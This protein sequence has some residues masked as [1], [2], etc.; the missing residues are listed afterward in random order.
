MIW[1]VLCDTLLAFSW[2]L[3]VLDFDFSGALMTLKAFKIYYPGTDVSSTQLL[4]ELG[5]TLQQTNDLYTARPKEGHTL[6][7]CFEYGTHSLWLCFNK[8]LQRH[9]KIYF[10]LELI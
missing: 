4:S 3:E 2:S 5:L 10:H 7:L 8:L 1:Y 6:I 9:I